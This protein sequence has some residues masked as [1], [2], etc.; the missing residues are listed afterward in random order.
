MHSSAAQVVFAR[1]ERAGAGCAGRFGLVLDKAVGL[2]ELVVADTVVEAVIALGP[3]MDLVVSDHNH[4]PF[5][6]RWA[7][8]HS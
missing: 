8:S 5:P 6:R 1:I 4:L 7:Y 3:E 2:D